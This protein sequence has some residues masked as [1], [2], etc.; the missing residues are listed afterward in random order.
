MENAF[1]ILAW[2]FRIFFKPIDLKPKTIDKLIYA[3]FNLHIWLRKTTP[4]NY[5]P[6]QAV[7]RGDFNNENNILG[8]WRKHVNN[9]EDINKL[10]SNNHK[11]TAEDVRSSLA[12]IF[13][14]ENP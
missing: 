14:E 12:N 11:Q 8:E 4:N 5:I 6:T 7:D 1:C 2:R 13:A 9:L 3:A 10:G